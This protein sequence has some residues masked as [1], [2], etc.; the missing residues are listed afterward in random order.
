M[1][2]KAYHEQVNINNAL[3]LRE[4]LLLLP[5]FC[6]DYFRGI[7]ASTSSRTRISYAY[8]LWI[9]FE[10]LMERNPSVAKYKMR[11]IPITILDA[12]CPTDIEEYL[13]EQYINEILKQQWDKP[14]PAS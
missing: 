12:I 4:Q 11:D 2:E 14:I 1:K 3:K 8:D 7:E 9:F 10:F 5:R 13:E 6:G